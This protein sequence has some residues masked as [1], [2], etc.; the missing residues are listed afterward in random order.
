MSQRAFGIDIGGTNIKM[1]LVDDSGR[2]LAQS[3]IP[4]PL[5]RSP[6][7][8]VA[9]I[10]QTAQTTINEITS[11]RSELRIGVGCPGLIGTKDGIVHRSPNLPNHVETPLADQLSSLMKL[12][13]RLL[14]DAN[15]CALAETHL[16]A[17][18]GKSPVV[19][20]TIGTGVGGAVIVDGHLQNGFGGFSGEIGHMT[21]DHDGELCPCGNRGCLEL[22]VGKKPIV[23]RYLSHGPWNA[24]SIA[25]TQVAGDQEKLSPEIIARAARSGEQR[26]ID[27]FEQ[28]GRKLGAGLVSLTN[29]FDPEIFIIGGGIA[30]AGELLFA[31]AR[32]LLAQQSIARGISAVSIAKAQLGPEAGFIGAAF[33]AMDGAI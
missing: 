28:V 4:T 17:G 26:A 24:E 12:P 15:A 32:N 22:F 11:D 21:I 31:P 14:N 16:G 6:E 10:A 9:V 33:F 27:T 13:V 7:A 30:E 19:V 29:I 8:G 3:A 2:I 18:R 23:N 5:D 20:L 25:F 1:G